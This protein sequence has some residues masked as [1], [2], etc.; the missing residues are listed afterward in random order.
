MPQ[1]WTETMV[2]QYFWLIL[3][4]FSLYLVVATQVLPSIAFALK[5]RKLLENEALISQ[6]KTSSPSQLSTISFLSNVLAPRTLPSTSTVD[7]S[8]LSYIATQEWALSK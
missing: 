6:V 2:S 8:A 5:S 4:L 7:F 3:V 1:L